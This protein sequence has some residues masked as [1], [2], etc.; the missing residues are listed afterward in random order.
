LTR[1]PFARARQRSKRASS[2]VG[3]S[4]SSPDARAA[5]TRGA[6][7]CVVED[8][9]RGT[10]RRVVG[11]ADVDAVRARASDMTTMTFVSCGMA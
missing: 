3:T 10:A 11:R 5:T 6:V 9:G 2:D 1:I 4:S 8:V 7:R